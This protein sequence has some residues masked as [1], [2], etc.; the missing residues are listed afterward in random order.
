MRYRVRMELVTQAIHEVATTDKGKL[1]M[2]F[3]PITGI[4]AD[5]AYEV[6]V[7]CEGLRNPSHQKEDLYALARQAAY[8]R[9]IPFPRKRAYQLIA[10]AYYRII[11]RFV[12][13]RQIELKD[14][15]AKR[16]AEIA[17]QQRQEAA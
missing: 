6:I 14:L 9:P 15:R 11:K 7:T 4:S 3:T 17:A 10:M 1:L 16:S 5:L 8:E 12:R 13:A 2:D